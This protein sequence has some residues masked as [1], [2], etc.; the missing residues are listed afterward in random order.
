[1]VVRDAHGNEL[2]D[3]DAVEVLKNIRVK[4]SSDTVTTGTVFKN[5]RLNLHDAE[6]IECGQGRNIVSLQTCHIRRAS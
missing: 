6:S 5:I 2:R 3:D 4:G 1:M